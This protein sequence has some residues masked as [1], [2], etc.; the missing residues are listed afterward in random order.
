M[1]EIVQ[2]LR[3]ATG[4]VLEKMFFVRTAAAGLE[5]PENAG[6]E[7]EARLGFTGEPGGWL[8]L[9]VTAAAARSIAADFLGAEEYELEER[10]IEEVV[11]ELANMICGSLLSRLESQATFH[12]SSPAIVAPGAGGPA[13]AAEGE[14]RAVYATAVGRGILTVRVMTERPVCSLSEKRAS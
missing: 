9:R 10:Q 6:V 14:S 1:V 5:A 8:G 3:E 4:E 7:M 12:L 13:G 11:C 2:A